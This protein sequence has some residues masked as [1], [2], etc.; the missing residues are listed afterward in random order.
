MR[1]VAAKESCGA[2]AP[3]RRLRANNYGGGNDNYYFVP[4]LTIQQADA[5]RTP[6][7]S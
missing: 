2:D 3:A 6:V 1:E 4:A 5:M 7:P